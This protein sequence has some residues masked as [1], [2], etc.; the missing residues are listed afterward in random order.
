MPLETNGSERRSFLLED[1]D[2]NWCEFR[3]DAGGP[4]GWVDEAFARGDVAWALNDIGGAKADEI[5][6]FHA[7]R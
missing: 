7:Q 1:I 2:S 6:L 5:R 3:Y 4:N